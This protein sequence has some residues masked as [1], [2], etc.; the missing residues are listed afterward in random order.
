MRHLSRL[1]RDERGS[2][3]VELALVLPLLGTMVVGMVDIS[4]GYSAKLQLEQ[5]AH[6]AIEKAMNSQKETTLFDTLVAESMEAANVPQS[7]VEVRYWLECNGV[8][9]N[10]GASTMAADYEKKCA[11]NIPYARYVSVRIQKAYAPMFRVRFAGSNADGTFTLVGRAG[12]RV[13]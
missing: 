12:I 10:T 9:Q 3:L 2:S 6:R 1:V 11:D 7:A 4:R 5:A 8:S 13:Q